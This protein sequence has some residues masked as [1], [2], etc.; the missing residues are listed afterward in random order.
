MTPSRPDAPPASDPKPLTPAVFHVLL[1]LADGPQ[2]GYAIMQ[3][4]RDTVTGRRRLG[5]GTIYG[6]L[7]R[8]EEA[9]LVRELAADGRRRSFELLPEGRAAL[10][11]EAHRLTRLAELVR[12]RN[13]VPEEG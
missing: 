3:A 6:T 4:V 9:G 2:H 7:Q 13:V 12:A 10:E 5:P 1:A 8:L 11:A